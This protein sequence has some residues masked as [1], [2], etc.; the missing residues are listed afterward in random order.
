MKTTMQTLVYAVVGGLL[1][2]S[3][4][5]MSASLTDQYDPYVLSHE[6][7]AAPAGRIDRMT[8]QYAPFVLDSEIVATKGCSDPVHELIADDNDP[9]VTMAAINMARNSKRC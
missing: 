9:F 3:P 5:A 8:D 2:A 6:I 1:L 7:D 4:V